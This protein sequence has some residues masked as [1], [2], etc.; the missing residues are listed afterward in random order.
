M[1]CLFSNTAAAKSCVDF[2][3]LVELFDKHEAEA[4]WVRTIFRRYL[5]LG[6]LNLLMADLRKQA[7][8]TKLRTLK[9]GETVGGIPFTR[10]ALQKLL[11]DVRAGKI[12]VILVYKLDRLTRS[13]AGLLSLSRSRDDRLATGKPACDRAA[14]SIDRHIMLCSSPSHSSSIPPPRW[15]G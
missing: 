2:A 1:G 10:G 15:G 13:L 12:D 14:I 9:T 6:S 4:E 11:E 5:E 7:I 8:L 3:K